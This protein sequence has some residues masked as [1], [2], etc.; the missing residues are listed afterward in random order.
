MRATN[1][2]WKHKNG[3]L[4]VK[5]KKYLSEKLKDFYKNKI[6]TRQQVVYNAESGGAKIPISIRAISFNQK[7]T[8]KELE[9]SVEE[10]LNSNDELNRI[11]FFNEGLEDEE[12]D[13]EEDKSL[14][15]N[16]ITIEVNIRGSVT[17]TEI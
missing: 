13:S 9:N 5:A 6:H 14:N 4:T 2:L 10:F 16:K 17:Y 7:H 8:L 15:Q 11:P 1:F 12:I 3:K